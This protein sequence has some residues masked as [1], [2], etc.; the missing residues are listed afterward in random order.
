MGRRKWIEDSFREHLKTERESRGWSQT[1]LA[2]MLSDSLRNPVHWTTIAKIEKGDRS[3]RID[4]AAAVADLFDMSVDALLGRQGPDDTTFAL[5]TLSG[6][7]RDAEG[8]I[9]QSQYVSAN[10]GRQLE[11]AKESF[12]LPHIEDLQRVARDMEGHLNDAH[13]RASTLNSMVS[14][15][16]VQ[17]AEEDQIITGE[18]GSKTGRLKTVRNDD[19]TT[20]KVVTDSSLGEVAER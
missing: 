11:E 12:D 17:T 8:K 1:E 18:P 2:K 13:A 4:E 16:V 5:V 10:I 20:Q 9:L 6:Y 3:V 14:E 19:G 7:I 15:A